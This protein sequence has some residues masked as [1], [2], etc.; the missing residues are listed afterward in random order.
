MLRACVIDFGGNWDDHFPHIEFAYNNNYQAIINMAP[1]EALYERRCRSL[2]GWF[3][4]A[5]VSLIGLEFV[6]EALKK[7]QLI[8][9][10]LKAAQSRQ[11]FY[12]DK[13]P[14]ELEFMVGDKVFLKVSPMK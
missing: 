8:R 14:Y 1:Y 9:E 11:K 10:R 3:E 7:V 12:S 2:V 6:C 5:E 13:R 4:L